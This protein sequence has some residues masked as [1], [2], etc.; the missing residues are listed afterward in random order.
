MADRLFV[1]MSGPQTA[2]AQTATQA[3][4]Q[5]ASQMSGG[6]TTPSRPESA[7]KAQ[8]SRA[9]QSEVAQPGQ[10]AELL[11]EFAGQSEAGT[12]LAADLFT[13]QLSTPAQPAL[14]ASP[15]LSDG[16]PVAEN[17]PA[18]LPVFR[19]TAVI[20]TGN[21]RAA[22][23]NGRTLRVGSQLQGATLAA[24]EP[25]SATFQLGEHSWVVMLRE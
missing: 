23:V 3:P 6:P 15:T 9:A 18:V 22:V 10:L 1:G 4:A 8:G 11:K 21:A 14:T 7:T 13:P 20:A 17:R 16:N 2:S 24:I 19:L 5:G 12:S 25:E